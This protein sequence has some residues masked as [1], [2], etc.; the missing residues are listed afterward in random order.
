MLK[1]YDVVIL[2]GGPAGSSTAISLRL[3]GIERI[4]VVE[5]SSYD[6]NRIGES[7][8]PDI[9]L[10]MEELELWEAFSKEEHEPCLGSCSSWG[11]NELGYN[12]FIFNPYGN[13]WHLDRRRF[14]AFLARQAQMKGIELRTGCHFNEVLEAD[15][16]RAIEKEE[17]G[18]QREGFD[19]VLSDGKVRTRIVVDAS[20]QKARFARKMGSKRLFNDRLICAI[21]FFELPVGIPFTQMTILEAVEN[22]WWYA[23]K[24]PDHKLVAAFATDP[25]ILQQEGSQFQR[26]VDGK[27]EPDPICSQGIGREPI[28]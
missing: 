27:S 25:E 8:P 16:Q 10:R 14:D 24:L 19:L 21:G 18:S 12:D 9:R 1:E 4:L 7:V 5:S 2:G 13:G 20:G 17:P 3:Q 11:S 26:P 28:Y 6:Q 23:A 22:G 15:Y